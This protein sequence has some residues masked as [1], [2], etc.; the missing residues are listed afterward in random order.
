MPVLDDA[1]TLLLARK[2]RR[3]SD[4]FIRHMYQWYAKHDLWPKNTDSVS[5]T[6][7]HYTSPAGLHGILSSQCLWATHIDYLNDTQ[8]YRYLAEIVR[9][10]EEEGLLKEFDKRILRFLWLAIGKEVGEL[11]NV[12]VC[13]FCESDN[14][15]SQWRAYG[16]GAAGYSLGFK[17]TDLGRY[18][19]GK[20]D[21]DS[22]MLK[23]DLMIRRVVY[24]REE[25]RKL[26]LDG[27]ES[28]KEDFFVSGKIPASTPSDSGYLSFVGASE[29]T[30]NEFVSAIEIL[31]LEYSI[32]FKNPSFREEA[33]WRIVFV[34]LVNN[35][36]SRLARSCTESLHIKTRL[37]SSMIIPY[38]EIRPYAYAGPN[39]NKLP[40]VAVTI[41]PSANYANAR[42]TID[43][44]LCQ[45]DFF[46]AKINNSGIPLRG[47]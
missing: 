27:L 31:V 32:S 35:S 18:R 17:G 36:T 41:G 29:E 33:E 45:Q 2:Q 43:L 40:I 23:R 3:H 21:A 4:N 20:S 10:V 14:L 16:S 6:L 47:T 9:E 37:Q 42:K 39:S 25:Q 12:Y 38:V 11:P 22:Y 8:E 1:G 44:L 46:D 13:C 15:L 34:D 26:L 30:Q 28:I 7:F 19:Q 5:A 24:E